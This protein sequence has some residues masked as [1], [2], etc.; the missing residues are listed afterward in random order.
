MSSG[1]A[2]SVDELSGEEVSSLL[3]AGEQAIQ[4]ESIGN[5]AVRSMGDSNAAIDT[6]A[7]FEYKVRN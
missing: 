1:F 7:F 3:G 4:M 2:V 5:V 6:A